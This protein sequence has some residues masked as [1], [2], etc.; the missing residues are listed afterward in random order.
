M[1]RRKSLSKSDHRLILKY[2]LESDEA[3]KKTL[4]FKILEKLGYRIFGSGV[5]LIVG[6]KNKESKPFLLL[7]QDSKSKV[8]KP[9]FLNRWDNKN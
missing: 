7:V 3:E 6:L 9:W 4:E 5:G 1:R 2:E 8:E